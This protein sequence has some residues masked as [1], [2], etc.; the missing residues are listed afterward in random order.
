MPDQP[1]V[2]TVAP[3]GPLTT[4]EQHP[5][6]PLTPAEIGVAVAEAAEA[7]AA[8]AHIHARDEEGK[9]TADPSVYGGN[10]GNTGQNKKPGPPP[11]DRPDKIKT[12]N[13]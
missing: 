6:V 10:W 4:R 9:P 1:V 2:V 5:Q 13:D 7:G 8:V 11:P 12:P 3:T